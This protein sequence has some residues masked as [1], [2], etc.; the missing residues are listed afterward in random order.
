MHYYIKSH[1]W[2]QIFL[3]LKGTKGIHKKDEQRVRRFVEGIWYMTRSGCQWRL[4]PSVYGSWR[5]IYGRFKS[6]CDRVIWQNLFEQLQHSADKEYI[7]I[8]GTSI[9]AHACAAGYGNQDTQA[10]GRSKGGNPCPC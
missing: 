2:E 5:A 1:E 7:M 3:V 6:W 10:L 4:L 9:R 8:D